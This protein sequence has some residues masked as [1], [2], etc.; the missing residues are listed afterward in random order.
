MGGTLPAQGQVEEAAPEPRRSHS[1]SIMSGLR[2]PASS[3]S[4]CLRHVRALL[5]CVVS[6]K[7]EALAQTSAGVVTLGKYTAFL[8]VS[9]TVIPAS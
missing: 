5:S 6:A 9:V 4:E 3:E 8:C 7:A 1:E 2:F